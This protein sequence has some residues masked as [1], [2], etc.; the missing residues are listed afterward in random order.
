MFLTFKWMDN[1]QQIE[2]HKKIVSCFSLLTLHAV[3]LLLWKKI[4]SLTLLKN[5]YSKQTYHPQEGFSDREI[6]MFH[7][8]RELG[9]VSSLASPSF[10]YCSYQKI[11]SSIR[12]LIT[13]H[14]LGKMVSIIVFRQTLYQK[15]CLQR[16]FSVTK[17]LKS[18]LIQNG[19]HQ[20]YLPELYS[21]Y[22]PFYQKCFVAPARCGQSPL[23]PE[24]FP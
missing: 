11:D 15:F 6:R 9:R 21:S 1:L 18:S 20:D 13:D 23:S 14:I 12:F 4:L 2:H 7:L 5:N 3:N 19:A 17:V 10:G 24:P 16:A 8:G 22:L